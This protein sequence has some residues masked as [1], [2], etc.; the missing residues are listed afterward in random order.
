[1]CKFHSAE[2]MASKMSQTRTIF[3]KYLFR[4]VTVLIEL[5]STLDCKIRELCGFHEPLANSALIITGKSMYRGR[6]TPIVI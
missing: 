4:F 1:M 3:H 6:A 2:T 5:R